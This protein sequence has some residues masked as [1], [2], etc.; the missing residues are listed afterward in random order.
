[1]ST[2]TR[3]EHG[4]LGAPGPV[5]EVFRE[6]GFTGH[7]FTDSGL[8]L[9]ALRGG[10]EREAH[11]SELVAPG[12]T[13]AFFEGYFDDGR[14]A[15]LIPE[16]YGLRTSERAWEEF[17][18]VGAVPTAGWREFE[19][20]GRV[21]YADRAKGFEKRFAHAEFAQG[22][23]VERK[24]VDD[25]LYGM[26][27]DEASGLGD[28][29]FRI[30]EEGA[31]SVFNNAFTDTGTN[32]DGMPL[33]GADN[34]GLCST[35]H[36]L[37]RED[38]ATQS[39]EGVRALTRGNIGLTRQD[40]QAWTDDTG[41]QLSVHP[42]EILVPP[43]LEDDA[44]IIARSSLD[45]DSANNAINPQAGR[46]RN[47]VWHYLTDPNAWFLMDSARRRRSLLWFDRIPLEFAR[48]ADFDTLQAKFRGYMRYS[49]G[50]RQW[51]WIYGNNPS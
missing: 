28:S 11:W 46:Y 50:W 47:V 33:A 17:L 9:P 3:A 21:S 49:Y 19:K 42:D 27:N 24:M 44:A 13:E 43:E 39:N 30:R 31:A 51:Q 18:G 8:V 7:L 41:G 29:A 38:S 32:P 20:T 14:R 45:P 48:E 4:A 23:T 22:M 26:L 1:M 2:I 34:V 15:S 5:L 10:V 36:P 37:S 25:E 12:L 35:A 40:M 16:I 6:G